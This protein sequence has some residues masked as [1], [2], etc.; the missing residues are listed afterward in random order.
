MNRTVKYI[1]AFIVLTAVTLAA[2]FFIVAQK[3]KPEVI[4]SQSISA[5]ES[6]L[7]G[8][9]ASI[10]KVDYSLGFVIDLNIKK[11]EI[12]E[13]QERLF[14]V[15]ELTL[16]LPLWAILTGGGRIDIE[17]SAPELLLKQEL[18]KG[19]NWQRILSKSQNGKKNDKASANI[20]KKDSKQVADAK[21]LSVPSFVEKS[22]LD[23]RIAD[24]R[25]KR[26]SLKGQASDF[27]VRRIL[28]KNL[29]F[30]K[31]TAVEIES[32]LS[33]S[34]DDGG[35]IKA[36]TQLVGEIALNELLER[37]TLS[38]N[39]MLTVDNLEVPGLEAKIPK[40]KN[41]LKFSMDSE[42]NVQATLRSQGGSLIDIDAKF[43]T[44]NQFHE[45]I[46]RD[47][48]V[49]IKLAQALAILPDDMRKKIGFI[50][51]DKAELKSFGHVEMNLEK[52]VVRPSIEFMTTEPLSL[53][54]DGMSANATMKGYF[55]EKNYSVDILG[56]TFDGE[57]VF[58]A[59]GS[60]DPMNLPQR[61]SNYPLV[62]L[63]AEAKD[64]RL[65]PAFIRKTMYSDDGE[66]VKS[67]P[68]KESSDIVQQKNE[69]E[70]LEF[71]PFD[72]KLSAK[73]IGLGSEKLALKGTLRGRKD[74]ISSSNLELNYSQG[75]MTAKFE[76]RLPSLSYI[77]HRADITLAGF[78]LRGFNAFLPPI[79][80]GV[81][82]EF[83]GKVDAKIIQSSDMKYNINLDLKAKDGELKDLKLGEMLR[84]LLEGLPMLK[85]KLKNFNLSDE[86]ESLALLAEATEKKVNVKDFNLVGKAKSVQV[87]AKGNVAMSE[88][89]DSRVDLNLLVQDIRSDL[90]RETGGDDIPVRLEGKGFVLIPKIKYT[91]DKLSTRLVARETKKQKKNLDKS[92]KKEEQKL[93]KKV[94][95]KAKELFKGFKL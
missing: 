29:N 41:I 81:G 85:G 23:L 39:L 24:F 92:L 62:Q 26:V 35:L 56:K 4:K 12:A 80:S 58:N 18:E 8:T 68:E 9:K 22:R 91:T 72:L 2:L 59:R 88:N 6:F 84:P 49:G 86:F 77:S 61:L 37:D 64:M 74:K 53:N 69:V 25:F 48:D 93:R 63:S 5:I 21:S 73:N 60:L 11:L 52:G 14:S 44:K 95:E 40:L 82:G 83:S 16:H 45:I 28:L 7:P 90:M 13:Q 19:S 32:D 51:A 38:A 94:E 54:F 27:N 1:S 67:A 34:L 43:V 79:V 15:E 57:L 42:Q 47:I 10:E 30:K 75:K 89:N 3:I 31:T 36:R 76:T 17:V 66:G 71:P 46:I 70:P 87:R 50:R 55:K 20:V 65:D 78:Q 33:H